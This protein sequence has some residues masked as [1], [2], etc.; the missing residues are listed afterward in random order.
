MLREDVN[1]RVRRIA[2]AKFYPEPHSGS[3]CR[4]TPPVTT[5]QRKAK[6]M[7][8]GSLLDA[9]LQ[10]AQLLSAIVC[11]RLQSPDVSKE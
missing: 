8:A 5:V 7:S 10:G 4:L 3:H 2:A 9:G 11:Y 6:E 1:C